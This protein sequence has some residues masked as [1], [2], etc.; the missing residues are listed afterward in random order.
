MG[1]RILVADDEPRTVELLSSRLRA[2]GYEVTTAYDA[3]QCVK[4][5]LEERPDLI[6]L[7]LKMP[8]GGG[9][10]A[11]GRLKASPKTAAIPMIF[12]TA[13][14]F[15]AIRKEVLEMGAKDFVAKPFDGDD[16]LK[17]VRK[18]F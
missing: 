12:V 8:A 14:P 10:Y 18:A 13:Y 9:L 7:D 6:I 4:I 15:E 1:K 16:L 2:N 11:F 17:K 3:Q 5:A